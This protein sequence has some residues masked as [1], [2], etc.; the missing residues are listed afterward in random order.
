MSSQNNLNGEAQGGAV[1]KMMKYFFPIMIVW[2]ARTYPSGLA[3]YWFI[4]QFMQIF[5]NIRFNQIR[6]DMKI[7]AEAKKAA[8]KHRA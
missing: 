5:F 2:L 4:S 8:K 1:M 3:I 7:K 6:K